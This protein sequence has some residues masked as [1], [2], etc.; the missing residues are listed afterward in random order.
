MRL[1][2]GSSSPTQ[3]TSASSS[4]TGSGSPHL[5]NFNQPHNFPPLT[6]PGPHVPTPQY[7][8]PN[9]QQQNPALDAFNTQAFK[10]AAATVAAHKN[11][12]NHPQTPSAFMPPSTSAMQ[13]T[14]TGASSL[15][16]DP[17]I[18]ARESRTS[19]IASTFPA[20]TNKAKRGRMAGGTVST[21][22][23]GRINSDTPAYNASSPVI[24]VL[25]GFET[26]K[27][28]KWAKQ[29]PLSVSRTLDI[30]RPEAYE[31][32]Q[33]D[34]W[35]HFHNV[36]VPND[37][38][39]SLDPA[40]FAFT[41][42]GSQNGSVTNTDLQWWFSQHKA[43]LKHPK[44][45][46]SS[47]S[48]ALL[49][50]TTD[51]MVKGLE[52]FGRSTEPSLVYTRRAIDWI[53][54]LQ[55]TVV[56]DGNTIK[57]DFT[58]YRWSSDIEKNGRTHYVRSI[59]IWNPDGPMKFISKSAIINYFNLRIV[60][61]TNTSRL[62]T[63]VQILLRDFVA[64][65]KTI[66]GLTNN[67]EL[68]KTILNLRLVEHTIISS[69]LQNEDNEFIRFPDTL[70][71]DE[72]DNGG[73]KDVIKGQQFVTK[74]RGSGSVVTNPQIHDINPA[75]VWGS[76]NG[77]AAAVALMTD[78]HKCLLGCQLLQLPKLIRIPVQPPQVD[79]IWQHALNLP[80]GEKVTHGHVDLPTYLSAS[81]RPVARTA[82][83]PPQILFCQ[84][85]F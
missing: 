71:D 40:A 2:G 11:V 70:E 48:L 68:Y 64:Y 72:S 77:R 69:E 32:L 18:A 44:I 43:T 21:R 65:A 60:A 75:N 15:A 17:F 73:P 37:M 46:Q 42:L 80:N 13:L 45:G 5:S 49:Y 1:G 19:R 41:T 56:D 3:P 10:Q 26:F 66:P 30:Y 54:G 38:I 82:P 47:E 7:P 59:D 29:K 35:T 57:S 16:F 39:D 34:L 52:S 61:T 36:F 85:L 84:I 6:Y 22:P 51:N 12:L 14:P 31:D 9:T 8:Y 53:P 24:T 20:N 58:A 33:L 76:R 62:Y 50:T 74:L 67:I 83:A 55:W 25:C 4:S 23:R 78:Q 63:A 27:A 81:A 28:S 79:L